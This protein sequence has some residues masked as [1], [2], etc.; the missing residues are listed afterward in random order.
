MEIKLQKSNWLYLSVYDAGTW[1]NLTSGFIPIYD[2]SGTVIAAIG[3]DYSADSIYSYTLSFSL[4]IIG[5]TALFLTIC[6]IYFFFFLRSCFRPVHAIIRSVKKMKEGD[7]TVSFDTGSKDEIGKISAELSKMI[8]SLRKIISVALQTSS[9]LI[10]SAKEIELY[11]G[12]SMKSYNEMAQSVEEVTQSVNAQAQDVVNGHQSV[13]DL[14]EI[15]KK[16][17]LLIGNLNEITQSIMNAKK[18]GS[19][20]VQTLIDISDENNSLV[21]SVQD[22]VTKTSEIAQQINGICQ[23]IQELA[24]QTNMLSLNAAIEASRAGESGRGFAVVADEIRKLAEQSDFSAKEIDG[25]A[26]KLDYNSIETITKMSQYRKA[27]VRQQNSISATSE[28]FAHIS[29]A[30][31]QMHVSMKEMTVYA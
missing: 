16:N 3:C 19:S 21:S 7:L 26:S 20:S 14:V 9:Q 28:K 30:I 17:Q 12:Q 8:I 18:E 13:I 27:L 5:I 2:N 23:N 25:M 4:K 31:E 10:S 22:D 29:N 6:L 24:N 15:M 1:G 11:S